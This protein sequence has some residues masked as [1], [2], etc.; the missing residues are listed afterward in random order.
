[1]LKRWLKQIGFSSLMLALV[2]C[3][4]MKPPR[5]YTVPFDISRAG[6]SQ[7][8]D[9]EVL[10]DDTDIGLN[11]HFHFNDRAQQ[12]YLRG[13][14]CDDE[15]NPNST[16]AMSNRRLG[17]SIP[18]HVRLTRGDVVLLDKLVNAANCFSWSAADQGVIRRSFGISLPRQR[19]KYRFE[20]RNIS[21]HPLFNG[22][23]VE[24]AIPGDRKV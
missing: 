20:I 2:A 3:N 13:K 11:M 7:T 16:F 4:D 8:I 23:Q 10:R 21:A 5:P 1:M 18:M 12:D 24:I 9:F 14:V 17:E 19:G 22:Y 15:P 6:Y